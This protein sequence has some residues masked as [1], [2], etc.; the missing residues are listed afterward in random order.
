MKTKDGYDTLG[1][2]IILIGILVAIVLVSPVITI[3]SLNTLF[4]TNI[5]TNVLTYLATL[6][7]TGL[8][9]GSNGIKSR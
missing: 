8:I 2:M 3:W 1:L 4:N 5:E 9:A 6:W 7:L